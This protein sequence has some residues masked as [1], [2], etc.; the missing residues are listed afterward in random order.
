MKKQEL[1]KR[2][3]EVAFDR[4]KRIKDPSKGKRKE[5]R[6]VLHDDETE[7][8]EREIAQLRQGESLEDYFDDED[9]S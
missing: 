5:T 3:K 9:D 7:D 1:S 6:T 8:Y 4:E 2:K